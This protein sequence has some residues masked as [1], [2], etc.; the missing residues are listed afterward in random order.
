MKKILKREK[1][2]KR[3]IKKKQKNTKKN[4]QNYQIHKKNKIKI[5]KMLVIGS[6][7][8]LMNRKI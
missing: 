4:I 7:T 1:K 6:R 5:Q 3:I 2:N 8:I